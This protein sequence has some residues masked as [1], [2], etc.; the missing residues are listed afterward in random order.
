MWFNL[1]Q[2]AWVTHLNKI[3]VVLQNHFIN[4]PSQNKTSK[5]YNFEC[6]KVISALTDKQSN[7]HGGF[8][9]KPQGWIVA[10]ENWQRRRASGLCHQLL[11]GLPGAS[12]CPISYDQGSLR[13][14]IWK[15][16]KGP[17]SGVILFKGGLC[18]LLW[19]KILYKMIF[20][21]W[22]RV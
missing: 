12:S 10:P 21:M 14:E 3:S 2:H 16:W 17:F 4:A 7:L 18:L 5:L 6:H 20:W 9:K 19:K 22:V 11:W 15:R 1:N 8:P 13:C